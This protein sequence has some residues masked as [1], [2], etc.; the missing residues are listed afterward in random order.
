M[1]NV[2]DHFQ[3]EAKEFDELIIKLVPYY[4]RMLRALVSALPLPRDKEIAVLDLGCGTGTISKKVKEIF[5][6]AKI[7]CF[8]LAPNMLA[9]AKGKLAEY[10]EDIE[11]EEGQFSTMSFNKKY[12]A[13]VSSL[14]LHH[15][16][17]D[18]KKEFYKV[19]YQKIKPG[20][21]FYNAD[22]VLGETAYLQELN[23]A[24]W[25]E[26]MLRRVSEEE[27]NNKWLPKYYAEDI[28]A[29]LS[30]HLEWLK[31]AGFKDVDVIWKYYG[32][33]V[34]GGTKE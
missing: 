34:Y 13:V 23:I 29:K 4:S 3:G 5:P 22:V 15:L 18:D 24:R 1:K 27:I 30:D 8:D 10:G 31:E 16:T 12:D 26:F 9:V 25:K 14:A 11:F 17:N 20:G 6:Q 32:G 2:K 21:V 33:A 7:T 19:L 28:P